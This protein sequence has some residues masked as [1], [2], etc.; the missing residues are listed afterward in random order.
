MDYFK[1]AVDIVVIT[2][3]LDQTGVSLDTVDVVV[4]GVAILHNTVQ[5]RILTNHLASGIEGVLSGRQQAVRLADI[6]LP[7]LNDLAGAVDVVV[8][9]VNYDQ[10]GIG[11]DALDIVIGI[12]A[13]VHKAVNQLELAVRTKGILTKRKRAF[14]PYS[15]PAEIIGLGDVI[16]RAAYIGLAC[17]EITGG[18]V[19]VV[20]IH[21]YQTGMPGQ[22]AING[23]NDQVRRGSGCTA[24]NDSGIGCY[25]IQAVDA[26]LENTLGIKD[27]V[28]IGVVAQRGIVFIVCHI[29][30]IGA[31]ALGI[32]KPIDTVHRGVSGASIQ[33]VGLTVDDR[34][35][36]L[37]QFVVD[38]ILLAGI[39]GD[40]SVKIP[41][42]IKRDIFSQIDD[43][44]IIIILLAITNSAPTGKF[45]VA[46]AAGKGICVQDDIFT[47]G[48][49][50][51]HLR[52]VIH[53]RDGHA[54]LRNFRAL[55]QQFIADRAV[56][57]A[58]V[59]GCR[60]RRLLRVTNFLGVTL[61]RDHFLFNN[62]F[63]ADGAVLA[64]GQASLG[65]GSRN[66]RIDD[67]GVGDG[68][69][70]LL[71]NKNLIA[72]EAVLALGQAGF[73][74]GRLDGRVD[75]LGMTLGGDFLLCND[76]LVADRAVLTLGQASL[77][78]GRCNCR[79]DDLG[80]TGCGDLFHAGENCIAD[81]AL[82]T[83]RVTGFLAGSGLFRNFNRSMSSRVDCFGLGCIANCAGVGLDTGVLTGRRGRDHA[84]IPA[85]TLG[86]NLFLRF[87]NRSA[88][89][90]ADA[91]RQT[92]F[93]AGR[94]LARN[95]LL[96]VAGCGNLSLCNEN[97]V[98]NGA[99]LT[100][101]QASLGTGS[102]NGRINDLGVSR[103]GDG[104]AFLH[105]LVADGAVGVAGVAGLGAGGVLGISHLSDRM[106]AAP[107]GVEGGIFRQGDVG[108]I[109]IGGAAA[110]G[111]GSPTREVVALAGERVG[112]QRRS[113]GGR[114]LL[115]LD[116]RCAGVVR[117]KDHQKALALEPLVNLEVILILRL[118][119]GVRIA[120]VVI[121][122]SDRVDTDIMRSY[123]RAALCILI[124]DRLGA[125]G[126]L[127]NIAAG[128]LA[129]AY[130]RTAFCGVDR[131]GRN[132]RAVDI[133][134]GVHQISIGARIA[135]RGRI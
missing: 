74:A 116:L 36:G 2:V 76:D 46:F 120:S 10:A 48:N 25:R 26:A 61:G 21:I 100:L 80:M 59:T 39:A 102:R 66:S 54:G 96:G 128:L 63:V 29:P 113:R 130:V 70:R 118:T 75:N 45:I 126:R 131:A 105:L 65:T 83:R 97:L 24:A 51:G 55:F 8:I 73:G 72:D 117:V 78:A 129:G 19:I 52:I 1:L 44:T 23:P 57:V 32:G 90:A 93:G 88:D 119:F 122:Q 13:Y 135:F 133:H 99:V 34:P 124:G 17:L 98:A 49:A 9:A 27:E 123:F 43:S 60:K 89:R 86:G 91:I 69:N 79:V 3:D 71:C 18:E 35:T 31:I 82:G 37:L 5:R 11:L 110:V 107:L 62:D 121:F 104:L 106:A 12:V 64:L 20:A 108:A 33:I 77:G 92:R 50:L 67:L 115:H 84:G 41:H 28:G 42:G 111:C 58:G 87:D 109:C 81:R 53:E 103:G 127:H 132:E 6:I 68:G 101:G 14:A 15:R 47:L 95:G 134:K 56:G 40:P 114:N 112:E 125:R 85:V 7:A 22:L 94:G 30:C 16:V 4:P 38:V